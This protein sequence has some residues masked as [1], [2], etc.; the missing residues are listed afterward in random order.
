MNSWSTIILISGLQITIISVAISTSPYLFMG[1]TF[2]ND[3]C[4]RVDIG[5]CR[6]C[7][8][9]NDSMDPKCIGCNAQKNLRGQLT[10]DVDCRL[11]PNESTEE[12][13]SQCNHINLSDIHMHKRSH[14]LGLFCSGETSR[15]ILLLTTLVV[16]L[17]NL[18][19]VIVDN[20]SKF[21]EQG[22]TRKLSHLTIKKSKDSGSQANIGDQRTLLLFSNV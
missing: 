11:C 20:K 12:R 7:Y 13:C 15:Y 17:M 9:N 1:K 3:V 19:L 14:V 2:L 8:T 18:L 21:T 5:A 4:H 10:E 16:F 22:T 6:G